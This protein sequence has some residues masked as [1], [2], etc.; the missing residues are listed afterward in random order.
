LIFA[1]IYT[2]FVSQLCLILPALFFL[3]H[4][5]A[6]E[7]EP[8][9]WSHLPI[10][11]NFFGGGYAHTNADITLDPVLKIEDGEAEIYSWVGKYIR[12]LM[13]FDRTAR[14]S[15]AQGYQDGRWT[16]VL[17]GE[18]KSITRHGLT[19]TLIRFSVNLYGSP[20]MEGKE[21]AAYRASHEEETTVG[22]GISVQLPTGDYMEDRLINIGSNRFT[23]RPQIGAE[24]TQGAWSVESTLTAVLYT[25]N[26]EFYNGKKLEN[27]PLYAIGSHLTYTLSPGVWASISGGYNYGGSSTV[28]GTKKHDRKQ[29]IASALSMGFPISRSVGVKL[30]YIGFRTQEST[31]VDADTFVAGMSVFW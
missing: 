6:E 22:V 28:N 25:N 13:L 20:P 31:G 12:S 1:V 21:Y 15:V 3:P 16:G 8:K 14:I 4:V 24:H 7:L 11:T 23:F 27:E 10:N 30:S 2:R 26:D 5:Q 17:D 19:D 29:N 18:A 9:R